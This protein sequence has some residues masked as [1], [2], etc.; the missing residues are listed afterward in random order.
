MFTISVRRVV[1]AEFIIF[2][3]A[4]LRIHVS[5]DGQNVVSEKVGWL[6]GFYGI[7]TFVGYLMPNVVLC[8]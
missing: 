7:S 1:L 2:V 5:T 3:F 8:K 6:V 4:Y